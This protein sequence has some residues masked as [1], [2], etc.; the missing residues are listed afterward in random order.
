MTGRLKASSG[1]IKVLGWALP[2]L[3]LSCWLSTGV[4]A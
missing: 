2:I 1:L 4:Q 3:L